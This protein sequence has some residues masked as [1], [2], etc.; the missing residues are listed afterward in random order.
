M[1]TAFDREPY[2]S[3]SA[4]T[5]GPRRH[6]MLSTR[7]TSS[8]LAPTMAASRGITAPSLQERRQQHPILWISR[9]WTSPGFLEAA[10]TSMSPGWKLMA[11]VTPTESCF[12]ATAADCG[13]DADR[14]G[15]AA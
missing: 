11:A 6:L 3:L 15:A 12:A 1:S 14:L 7:W 8:F 5:F 4:V 2:T 9:S 13:R 10:G